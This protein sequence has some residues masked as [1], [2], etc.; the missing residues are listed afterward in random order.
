[1]VNH[2]GEAEDILQES[3]IEAFG[4]IDSFRGESTFGS[5]LKK[6]VVNRS[7]NYLKKRKLELTDDMSFA[8]KAHY[9]TAPDAEEW[10]IK[11]VYEAMQ[12]LP[13]GYRVVLSLYLLEGYDHA[14]IAQILG[15]TEST[16]KSQ[17]NRA[18]ARLREQ[19][20]HV[21]YGSI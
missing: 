15:I 14:E 17:Y 7:V 19:L 21:K 16:S 10:E 1:M 18:K 4:K 6:I 12:A 2:A 3:F 9:D 13:D 11:K 8:D 20:K 5:W